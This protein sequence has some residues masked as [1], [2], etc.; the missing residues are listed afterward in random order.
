MM[1]SR[2]LSVQLFF[3]I[4]GNSFAFDGCEYAFAWRCG[5]TCIIS[6]LSASAATRSFPKRT[7]SGAAT[8]LALA[9]DCS[10]RK[11]FGRV[12]GKEKGCNDMG[13]RGLAPSALG[14]L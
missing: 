3:L 9:R 1:M 11:A 4:L 12:S 13:I 14:E 6:E 5:D 8:T 2:V 10:T 7:R